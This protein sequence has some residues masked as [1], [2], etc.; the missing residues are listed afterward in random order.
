MNYTKRYL[1]IT[2]F[3]IIVPVLCTL[4]FRP[5]VFKAAMW[6][7][8]GDLIVY[9][10]FFVIPVFFLLLPVIVILWY[11]KRS[12]YIAPLL[13]IIFSIGFCYMLYALDNQGNIFVFYE[14]LL[15]T[16][17]RICNIAAGL[18]IPALIIYFIYRKSKNSK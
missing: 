12:K 1:L 2:V 18:L 11:T 6:S 13:G 7:F 9:F 10:I 14:F 3:C 17:F 15:K 4:V 16:F 8:F 5:E